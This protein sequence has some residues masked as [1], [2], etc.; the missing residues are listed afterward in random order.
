MS[1]T[2]AAAVEVTLNGAQYTASSAL[3]FRYLF[4]DPPPPPPPPPS[5][6][7]DGDVDDSDGG[8]ADGDGDSGGGSGGDDDDDDDDGG[9]A[10]RRRPVDPSSFA[11]AIYVNVVEPP[12][13]P[14]LGATRVNV[15]GAGYMMVDGAMRCRFGG[16]VVE[17]S[18]VSETMLSCEA[19]PADVSGPKE[20]HVSLN[21]VE[22]YVGV[23][24]EYA[25]AVGITRLEPA[26][27]AR[28]GGG[29][30]AVMARAAAT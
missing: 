17:A 27:T 11:E 10:R 6:D 20:V 5:E 24:Y 8:G 30:V 18:F 9:G 25:D 4:A 26:S 15:S 21:A 12:V 23:L 28:A 14:V 16:V 1:A 3:S 22:W 19:P 13:G 29:E 2:G 7:S